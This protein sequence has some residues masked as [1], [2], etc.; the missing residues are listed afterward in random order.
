LAAGS[1]STVAW[2]NPDQYCYTKETVEIVNGER[3]SSKTVIECNDNK[4]EKL[5][6]KQAGQAKNCGTAQFEKVRGNSYVPRHA[7]YCQR[8]DGHW[9]VVIDTDRR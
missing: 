1:T 3:V 4:I 8:P 7:I 5:I 2:S 9:D 6:T